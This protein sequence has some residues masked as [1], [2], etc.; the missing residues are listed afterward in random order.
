MIQEEKRDSRT[1]RGCIKLGVTSVLSFVCAQVMHKKPKEV[2]I[3]RSLGHPTLW[4][5]A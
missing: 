4:N 2:T 5:G 3:S 1:V